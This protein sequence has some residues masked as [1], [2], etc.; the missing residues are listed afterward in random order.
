MMQHF[1]KKKV[2]ANS[3]SETCEDNLRCVLKSAGKMVS[4]SFS[5]CTESNDKYPKIEE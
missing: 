2:K 3:V 4:N 5:F 1:R